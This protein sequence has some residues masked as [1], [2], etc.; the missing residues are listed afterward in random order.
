MICKAYLL[1]QDGD[2][3]GCQSLNFFVAILVLALLY[4]IRR[5]GVADRV[6]SWIEEFS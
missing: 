4:V 3:R 6:L 1:S 5:R 2:D